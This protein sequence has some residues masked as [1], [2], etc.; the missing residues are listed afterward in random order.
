MLA[1]GFFLSRS[2][3]RLGQKLFPSLKDPRFFKLKVSLDEGG[4]NQSNA[5]Y[6]S[7]ECHLDLV[8]VPRS[9]LAG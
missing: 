9:S 4:K 6:F 7:N 2:L 3:K 8:L 1:A 5:N